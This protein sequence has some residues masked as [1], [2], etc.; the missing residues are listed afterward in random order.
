LPVIGENK[1]NPA[2]IETLQASSRG[3]SVKEI[4]ALRN[5]SPFTVEAQVRSIREKTNCH[6][7]TGAVAKA[8]QSG[9]I[10]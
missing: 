7:I 8:I 10:Q 1:L 5:R 4:A 9:I 6:G 3:F 2:E